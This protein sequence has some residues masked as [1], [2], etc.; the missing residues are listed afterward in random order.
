MRKYTRKKDTT[1]KLNHIYRNTWKMAN[2]GNNMN[3]IVML[4]FH[5][6]RAFSR[7]NK[8]NNIILMRGN[9]NKKFKKWDSHY[10]E[11]YCDFF[12]FCLTK[13]IYLRR[14]NDD[15]CYYNSSQCHVILNLCDNVSNEERA[16]FDN[17][18]QFN[19]ILSQFKILSW[20]LI[21]INTRKK[22]NK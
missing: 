1:K 15:C 10:N 18:H 2:R 19:K 3:G 16:D 9:R 17:V 8:N 14:W 6:K 22:I 20:K 5:V 7:M 11:K 12:C 21:M 4:A 13:N